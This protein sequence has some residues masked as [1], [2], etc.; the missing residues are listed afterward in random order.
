MTAFVLGAADA[1]VAAIVGAAAAKG[2]RGA[3][4]T[5]V[6]GLSP[7]GLAP[8]TEEEDAAAEEEEAAADEGVAIAKGAG[9]MRQERRGPKLRRSGVRRPRV[10]RWR[11]QTKK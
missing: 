5:G 11:C 9:Y 10:G 2:R 4:A 3:R 7:V 1:D 6:A 8:A